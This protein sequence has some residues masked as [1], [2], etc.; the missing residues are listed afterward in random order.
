M[1]QINSK[2]KGVKIS[3]K[4]FVNWLIEKSPENLPNGEIN[5][6]IEKFYDEESFLRELLRE[7]KKLKANGQNQ[8]LDFIVRARNEETKKD[9]LPKQIE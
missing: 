4:D 9:K 8:N 3:R 7:V 2:K 5:A 1:E 6:L